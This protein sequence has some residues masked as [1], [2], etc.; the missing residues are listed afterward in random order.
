MNPL[1]LL[2]L[3][4]IAAAFWLLLIRPQQRRRREQEQLVASL[5]PG[6]RIMTTAGLFG[7]LRAI[8]DEMVV[9]EVAPGVEL[10]MLSVAVARVVPEVDDEFDL[11]RDSSIEL[12]AEGR[13]AQGIEVDGIGAED[14]QASPRREADGG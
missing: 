13:G 14:P 12:G 8:R 1:D 11:L 5:A 6:Q 10:E 9:V 2:P 7:T 3:V 4:A